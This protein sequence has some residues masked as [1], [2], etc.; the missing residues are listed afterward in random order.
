[1]TQADLPGPGQAATTNQARVGD[2][3]MGGAE[4]A[5]P[6]QRHALAQG[7]GDAIDLGDVERFVIAQWGQDAGNGARQQGLACARRS[8]H[9]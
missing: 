3:V 5:L 9:E 8:C 1:M 2:G 4:G 7:T 6:D